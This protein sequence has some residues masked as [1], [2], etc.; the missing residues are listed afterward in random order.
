MTDQHCMI[1]L[2]HVMFENITYIRRCHHCRLSA[3]K[4]RHIVSAFGLQAGRDLYRATPAMTRDL[5]SFFC[6]LVTLYNNGRVPSPYSEPNRQGN[7]MVR[8]AS[9]SSYF[10]KLISTDQANDGDQMLLV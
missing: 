8:N 2:Y 7:K 10:V 6:S 5:V 9:M 4:F 1:K 3:D